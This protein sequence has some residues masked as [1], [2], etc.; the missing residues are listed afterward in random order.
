MA[1]APDAAGGGP[2]RRAGRDPGGLDRDR[3]VV[4]RAR[5]AGAGEEKAREPAAGLSS[6]VAVVLPERAVHGRLGAGTPVHRRA[7]RRL[8][9]RDDGVRHPRSAIGT[10]FFFGATSVS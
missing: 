5:D 9:G 4:G 1:P 6:A 2:V 7:P 10:H 3:V 8:H